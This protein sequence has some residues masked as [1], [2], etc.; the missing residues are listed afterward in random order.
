MPGRER[1]QSREHAEERA[2]AAARGSLQQY[3]L[4]RFET[5]RYRSEQR[6]SIGQRHADILQVDGLL[7]GRF[8]ARAKDCRGGLALDLGGELGQ[9]IHSRAPFGEGNVAG[10]EPGQRLVDTFKCVRDLG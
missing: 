7:D 2:L 1:P 4:A 3:R 8:R 9:P 10:D 5:Q 6:R